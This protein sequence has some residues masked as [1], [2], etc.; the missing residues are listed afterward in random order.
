MKNIKIVRCENGHYYDSGKYESCPH[1]LNTKEPDVTEI[2][3]TEKFKKRTNKSPI[4]KNDLKS[5]DNPDNKL[6]A[7][8]IVCIEGSNKGQDFKVK[9]DED[10]IFEKNCLAITYNQSENE[11]FI[12]PYGNSDLFYLNNTPILESEN[13]KS[14]DM[15]TIGKNKFIFIPLCGE[16]FKWGGNSELEVDYENIQ[17]K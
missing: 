3:S 1:C 17:K 13:L 2:K 11:F 8:W 16:N 15:I 9:T 10:F 7:G 14:Y 5:V 6:I 12:Q 4:G